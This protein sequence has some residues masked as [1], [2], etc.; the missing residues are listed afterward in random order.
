MASF[1]ASETIQGKFKALVC[2]ES[3]FADTE[4]G[5]E[6]SLET[7]HSI[8]ADKYGIGTKEFSLTTSYKSDVE[9]N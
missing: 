5:E 4:T 3:G 9:L 8:L 7:F 6:I 2:T 1:K